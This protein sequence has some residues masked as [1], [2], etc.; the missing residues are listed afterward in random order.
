M[1]PYDGLGNLNRAWASVAGT[2]EVPL[3]EEWG[4]TF[5]PGDGEPPASGEGER[6]ID[7]LAYSHVA[8]ADGAVYLFDSAA[9]GSPDGS[10]V[11]ALR[12]EGRCHVGD[13]I[14]GRVEI[15]PSVA[16]EGL[17]ES[18][19]GEYY[20]GIEDEGV[21]GRMS[22]AVTSRPSTVERVA[23]GHL[24]GTFESLEGQ[25]LMLTIP[26]DEGWALRVD[27]EETGIVEVLGAFMAAEVGPGSHTFELT[28]VPTGLVP[29]AVASAL[30]LAAA[31]L[32][33]NFEAK[34]RG[35]GCAGDA[36]IDAPDAGTGDNHGK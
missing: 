11:P 35:G 5:A 16:S 25:V 34:R 23:D 27:G 33:L 18:A 8:G 3:A 26:Y 1:S 36:S 15:G 17:L 10:T 30:G 28:F 4:L 19:S 31:V 22:E 7:S 13:T 6:I 24:R 32:Y 9:M 20:I 29:G 12:Y 2:D 21:L 14:E